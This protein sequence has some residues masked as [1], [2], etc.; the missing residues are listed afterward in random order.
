MSA[1]VLTTSCDMDTTN[2]GVI[3]QENY[4]ETMADCDAY[5]N[6]M[7]ALM[8]GKTGGNWNFYSDIQMDQF[9]GVVDNGN[10]G[11]VMSTGQ[12]KAQDNDLATLY[13]NLYIEINDANYFIP[14]AEKLLESE[15]LSAA[16]KELLNFYLGTAHFAR[17]YAYW[18]AFDKYVRYDATKLDVD[19]L[20]LQIVEKFEPSGNRSSYVGRS[21]IAKTVAYINGELEQAYNLI[22]AYETNVSAQYC[23][24]NAARVSSYTVAAL[25]ARFALLCNDFST[26]ATKAE[27][28]INSGNYA[29]TP[30]SDYVAMWTNDEGPELIFVPYGEQGQGGQAI[31]VNYLRNNQKNSSDYLPT[32]DALLAYDEGD[33]RFEAFFDV[34]APL[35][36]QGVDYI[37]YV[38][39]KFPGNPIFNTGSANAM[40]NKSKPFRL[41]ELYLIA[42]EAYAADGAQ[43]NESKANTY[44]NGL[45]KA[46]IDGYSNVTLSGAQLVKAI[47]DERGKELIGEGF[48]LGDLRRWGNGF[49]REA[50]YDQFAGTELADLA[51]LTEAIAAQTDNITYAPDDYRF[52]WPIPTREMQVNPQ[53]KGQQ[54]PGY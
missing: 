16:D 15:G 12:V 26:A 24:P 36:L 21:S 18:Y 17:A 1:A 50:G 41:A 48:R 53:L 8:R 30:S 14:R 19:G 6:G 32:V 44:L 39:N 2:F 11:G 45:R 43:K 7:Y 46:R 25:Q 42:A 4:L 51:E 22:K 38:F 31:G 28:V 34:Y 20:G 37:G 33:V 10:R 27:D 49:T 35:Q 52:V 13:Y 23:A 47:R 54:N 29:L 40:L 9:V 3:S 5:I